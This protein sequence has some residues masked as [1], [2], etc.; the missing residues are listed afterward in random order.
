M[1]NENFGKNDIKWGVQIGH[2]SEDHGFQEFWGDEYNWN[3]LSTLMWKL[4]D[5]P[6]LRVSPPKPGNLFAEAS[7]WNA[8]L[9]LLGYG[10]GWTNIGVGLR[11]W[12][13]D[14]YPLSNHILRTVYHTWGPS[15]E[16]LE[17]WLNS[18]GLI[19]PELAELAGG[20]YRERSFSPD[21]LPQQTARFREKLNSGPRHALAGR[22]LTGDMDPLH[23]SG[24]FSSGIGESA[25]IAE[26]QD[27]VWLYGES[28]ASVILMKFPGWHL[29]VVDGL[30]LYYGDKMANVT[31]EVSLYSYGTLGNFRYS[32]ET[33]RLYRT[34]VGYKQFGSEADYHK[35]GN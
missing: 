16:G 9:H 6:K 1:A 33:G 2:A 18:S 25:F 4:V 20:Q 11:T 19:T 26:D 12:R 3:S 17:I 14:G 13:L 8:A 35:A 23:L 7:W 31:I 29:T 5:V 24:H 10:M 21:D 22:F 15:I 27:P 34:L 28:N 32:P 30:R